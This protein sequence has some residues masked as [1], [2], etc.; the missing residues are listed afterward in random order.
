[1]PPVN[2]RLWLR[3]AMIRQSPFGCESYCI[4]GSRMSV[5]IKH[6]PASMPLNDAAAFSGRTGRSTA[7]ANRK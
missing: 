7:T 3:I 5:T 2:R 4:S 1:M 6:T